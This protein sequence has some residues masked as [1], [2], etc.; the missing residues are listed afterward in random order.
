MDHRS[1]GRLGMVRIVEGTSCVAEVVHGGQNSRGSMGRDGWGKARHASGDIHSFPEET[2]WSY[3]WV[4]RYF[5]LHCIFSKAFS[6]LCLPPAFGELRR[7][8]QVPRLKLWGLESKL[9]ILTSGLCCPL[10]TS[11]NT[12]ENPTLPL[13]N[14]L[15]K[16]LLFVMK[17]FKMFFKNI[18]V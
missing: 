12:A 13:G 7:K 8:Y 9:G 15:K 4:P 14:D 2:L 10:P 17:F 6:F 3:S 11:I 16:N 1:M 18:G 5:A